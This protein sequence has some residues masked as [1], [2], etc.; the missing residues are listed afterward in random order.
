MLGELENANHIPDSDKDIFVT[1]GK[2][3]ISKIELSRTN[4]R[5][6]PPVTQFPY[7]LASV[8]EETVYE[9]LEEDIHKK[10]T[11]K[12][13]T[14]QP[15]HSTSTVSSPKQTLPGR[16]VFRVEEALDTLCHIRRTSTKTNSSARG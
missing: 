10:T 13:P 6:G 7:Q 16:Q 9:D 8:S 4:S 3:I 15:L 12:T 5:A 1:P 11:T 2:E 14:T